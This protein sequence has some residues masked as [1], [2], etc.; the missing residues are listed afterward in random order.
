[1]RIK[2]ECP[3]MLL[4]SLMIVVG[5]AAAQ[6]EVRSDAADSVAAAAAAVEEQWLRTIWSQIDSLVVEQDFSLQETVVTGGVRGAEGEDMLM[7][8]YYFKGGERYSAAETLGRIT[9]QLERQ[10]RSRRRP[11]DRAKLKYLSAICSDMIGEYATARKYYKAVAK[12]HARSQYAARSRQ[13]LQQLG[14]S[15]R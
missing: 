12:D 11:A 5:Q 8:H 2:P 1:M 14:A 4:A 6:P 3:L 9:A 15:Q 7:G 10:L 13:R